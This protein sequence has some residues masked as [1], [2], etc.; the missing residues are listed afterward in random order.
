MRIAFRVIENYGAKVEQ[1]GLTQNQIFTL[2][3][4]NLIFTLK[5]KRL[6]NVLINAYFPFCHFSTFKFFGE[7]INK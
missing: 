3:L 6:K 4:S 7:I 1:L 5:K 2:K